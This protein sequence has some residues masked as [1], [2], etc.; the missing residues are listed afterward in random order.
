[1]RAIRILLVLAVVLGVLFVAADRIALWFAESQAADKAQQSQGFTSKPDVSIKGFPFLTQVAAKKLDDVHITAKGIEAGTGGQTL[2]IDRFSAD[3]RGVRLS[4]NFSSAVADT[5]DGTVLITYADLTKAV[6]SGI[7]VGYAGNGKVKL[8]ALGFTT[9]VEAT[10]ANGK[11]VRL[12]GLSG[13]PAELQALVGSGLSWDL[14]GLPTGIQLKSATATADGIQVVA[15]GT[16][17][18]L[19]N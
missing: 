12:G 17:V 10:L 13:L 2:R 3:L 8:S 18:V 4:G 7:T 9:T 15:S 16:H 6:P 1:M 5:A 19:A 14:S 11:T